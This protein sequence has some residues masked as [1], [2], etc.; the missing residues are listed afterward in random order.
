MDQGMTGAIHDVL[1]AVFIS[2]VTKN[3]LPQYLCIL[4]G[5][6]DGLFLSTRN[7]RNLTTKQTLFWSQETSHRIAFTINSNCTQLK[8]HLNSR[9]SF[10]YFVTVLKMASLLFVEFFFIVKLSNSPFWRVLCTKV[11]G[12]LKMNIIHIITHVFQCV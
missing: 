3:I 8:N 11:S 2:S 10:S 12:W 6:F 5:N 7:E 4:K 9:W 1:K